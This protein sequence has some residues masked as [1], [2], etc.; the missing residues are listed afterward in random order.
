MIRLDP[1]EQLLLSTRRH[2]LPALGRSGAL[3][4]GVILCG[5]LFLVV[6]PGGFGLVAGLALALLAALRFGLDLLRYRRDVVVVTDR[7]LIHRS[8]LLSISSSET[9]ISRIGDILV[10]QGPL[11]RLFDYGDVEIVSGSESGVDRLSAI[12]GPEALA[13]AL[14]SANMR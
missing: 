9:A 4:V 13:A 12:R 3:F 10:E 2:P 7:R 5:L 14:R 6:D 11:G 1:Q 8:G